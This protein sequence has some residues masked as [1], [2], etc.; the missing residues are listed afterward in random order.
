[1]KNG[2]LCCHSKYKRMK[3]ST[4]LGD[5]FATCVDILVKGLH[6]LGRRIVMQ[7]YLLKWKQKHS[8]CDCMGTLTRHSWI[9]YTVCCILK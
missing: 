4:I 8:L 3:F 5:D 9:H 1:M 7:L 6:W 2:Y